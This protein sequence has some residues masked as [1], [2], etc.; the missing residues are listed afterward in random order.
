M[1]QRRPNLLLAA[2]HFLLLGRRRPP[3]GGPLRHGPLPFP[4]RGW[5]ARGGEGAGG[6]RRRRAG[7]GPGR[8]LQGLL[9]DAPGRAPGAHR[10]TQH[11]DQRSRSVHRPPP[12]ARDHRRRLPRRSAALAPRPRDV[13][14]PQPAL[15]LLRLHLPPTVG[16]GRRGHA[17][18]GRAAGAPVRLECIVRGELCDLPRLDLPP[19]AGRSG[20]DAHPIDPTSED[21]AHWLLA[22]LW[23]DNLPRF[24]RLRGA[25]AIARTATDRPTVTRGDIIDDAARGSPR[26]FRARC[27]SWC[28]I[29][30]W[31]PT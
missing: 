25:L 29:P 30:G 15:R 18:R 6:R 28:S 13:G 24:A 11:A 19:I 17:R 27:R 21:G 8:R 2:V 1:A 12:R 22:C 7:P 26:A 16:R 14:G 31:R 23:P 9:P 5:A 4:D 10:R 3:L 20:I